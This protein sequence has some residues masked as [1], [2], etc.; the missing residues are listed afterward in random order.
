LTDKR[1]VGINAVG[2]NNELNFLTDENVK[3]RKW[4]NGPARKAC[5]T[6]FGPGRWLTG[7]MREQMNEL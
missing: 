6:A 4:K 1:G 7:Q 5:H 2:I 3:V